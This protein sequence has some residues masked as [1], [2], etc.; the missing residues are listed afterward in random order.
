MAKIDA[1][2]NLLFGILALQMDFISREALIRAMSTWAVEKAKPLAQILVEQSALRADARGLLEALVHK[3][4]EIHDNDAGQSLAAVG[5]IGGVHDDLKQVADADVQ[6]SL[7][8]LGNSRPRDDQFATRAPTVGT[9]SSSGLR[10]RIL[11]PYA[12]GGL[13]EVF[14]AEDQELHREVALKEIQS[15][16]ADNPESRARFLLEAEV[17]GGLEHP[18][19]VPVYGLGAYPDGRPFYAMRFIRGDSLDD[20]IRRYHQKEGPT[21]EKAVEFRKLLDSFL[22][23]CNAIEY[24]HSRGVVH[25]DLKPSNIMLGKFGETIVVDW[26]L[27]K[28]LGA[29]ELT[30]QSEEHPLKPSAISG[31]VETM[32]G[33]A[34]GTPQFMSPEQAIGR[35]EMLGPLSDIY[36]LGATL[37]AVLTGQPPFAVADVGEVLHR[38]Q[39]GDFRRPRQIDVRVPPALEA[40][41]LKAMALKPPDRYT[42]ARA[43]ADDI[44][45]WL[46]D[47]PVVAY[48]EP[49]G[50]RLGR[51]ARRHRSLVAGA[52]AL[53]LTAVAALTVST[54]LISREQART[55]EA[56]QRAEENFHT[57]LR[58]VNDML[59][60]VAEEQ[61]AN[62]PRMEKKRRAL[63]VK[64]K[65]YY[66]QFLDERGSDPNLR[67]ETA[68]AYQRLADISRLLG[69]NVTARTDYDRAIALLG[70]LIADTHGDPALR[71]V[72]A[73]SYCYLGEVQRVTGKN[74]EAQEA[75]EQALDQQ[76]RLA[77]EFPD[78]PA[79][80]QD[81][82]RTHYN[83][84]ILFKDSQRPQ[85]SE[86]AFGEAVLILKRLVADYPNEPTYQQH[87][88]RAYLN[89]GPVLRASGRPKEAETVYQQ[90]L[91]LQTGLVATDPLNPAFRYE[92]AVTDN[93]LGFLLESMQR[94][95]EATKVHHDAVRLLNELMVQFPSVPV[96]RKEL[97]NSQ[98]NLA[99]VLAR[100]GDKPAA[101]QNWRQ[102]LTIFEKLAAETPDVPD[103]EAG[104]GM[105]LGNLGWL[106]LQ[107]KDLIKACSN[108]EDG[109]RHVKRAHLAN[110]DRPLYFRLLRE[111]YSYLIDALDQLG[112]KSE[113]ADRRKQLAELES[114]K[115]APAP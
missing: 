95:A 113:A 64:A 23:V 44:E 78:R 72:L 93:N 10:F 100:T 58:A 74:A 13:G 79:F 96:Y 77:A 41:C 57:A 16:Q 63:L 86:K 91:R 82:A 112:R 56:R 111:Q 43:L 15:R 19:I 99:I 52:A 14:V 61:L 108:L 24:A 28:P 70:P 69:D 34:V 38:V 97:A 107:Q 33:A 83:L 17:T 45:H 39:R 30:L 105:V 75:Y 7:Q 4:L 37:F 71:Q 8:S 3:H 31:T 9:P 55:L 81:L 6:G 29:V 48:R 109:I 101:E 21:G 49:L 20:A 67:K 12:R 76:K 80:R 104:V 26:G 110:P 115:A 85:L 98:N 22:D 87:L 88:A 1:D 84:G 35:L 40:I 92:L 25:R 60:E 90:A 59:T 68:L 47:E 51:W 62:E 89:L 53:L 65:N 36:S 50:P 73:E 2:R 103:Y 114:K 32:A 54:V 5:S 66:E 94:H 102:A 106:A 18:C 11:R 46:A 42:S 27:A